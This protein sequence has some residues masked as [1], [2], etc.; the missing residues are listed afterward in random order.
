MDLHAEV[1]FMHI[2]QQGIILKLEA[3]AQIRK[4]IIGEPQGIASMSITTIQQTTCTALAIRT[5]RLKLVAEKYGS[6]ATIYAK[7]WKRPTGVV[8][9]ARLLMS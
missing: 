9:K 1:R 2:Q 8:P 6:S 7:L 4:L 5:A 3:R